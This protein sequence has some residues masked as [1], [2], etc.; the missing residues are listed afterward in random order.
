MQDWTIK[1]VHWGRRTTRETQ[2][3]GCHVARTGGAKQVPRSRVARAGKRKGCR[4]G[5]WQQDR[6]HGELVAQLGSPLPVGEKRSLN[7]S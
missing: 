3:R 2:T 6:E 7:G 5:R 1:V 4:E